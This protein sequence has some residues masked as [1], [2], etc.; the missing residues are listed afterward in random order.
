MLEGVMAIPDIFKEVD[1]ILASEQRSADGMNWCIAPPFVVETTL[2]VKVVEEF[3]IRLS[4]PEI[5][6][7]DFE[8]GPNYITVS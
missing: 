3:A 8:V 4:A 5:E 6:V 1:L 2:L 7:A